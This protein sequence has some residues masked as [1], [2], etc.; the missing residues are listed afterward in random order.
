MKSPIRQRPA[1]VR[2]VMTTREVAAYLHCHP[3]TL[4]RLFERGEI[5]AF[6]LGNDLRFLRSAIDEWIARMT[7]RETAA[8]GR[9]KREAVKRWTSAT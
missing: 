4:Y 2:E 6:K 3:T 9:G 1:L 5:P 7:A 8:G